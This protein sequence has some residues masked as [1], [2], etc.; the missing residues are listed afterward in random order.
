[1]LFCPFKCKKRFLIILMYI[2]KIIINNLFLI[3]PFLI[4]NNE[5]YF[6]IFIF[7]NKSDWLSRNLIKNYNRKIRISLRKYKIITILV[8][9]ELNNLYI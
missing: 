1:M 5:F 6:C 3:F 9:E 2:V 8:H 7:I 4:K